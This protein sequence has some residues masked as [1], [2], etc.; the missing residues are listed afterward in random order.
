MLDSALE[1]RED[2]P[3]TGLWNAGGAY[4]GLG[5]TLSQGRVSAYSQALASRA[6]RVLGGALNFKLMELFWHS[7]P[8]SGPLTTSL[9]SYPSRPTW[10]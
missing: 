9:L 2:Y 8:W 10:E 7:H 4:V 1:Q 6:A 3:R 5:G